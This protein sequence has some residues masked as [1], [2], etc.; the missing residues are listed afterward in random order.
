[1]E[2]STLELYRTALRLRRKL[3]EGETLNWAEESPAGVLHF[4]RG[5]GWRCVTNLSAE[6]VALPAGEVL[7]TSAPL[8]NSHLGPDATAWL[9]P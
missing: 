3:T 9:G 8:Q 4:E 7:L 1:M 5:N 6:P 2:G